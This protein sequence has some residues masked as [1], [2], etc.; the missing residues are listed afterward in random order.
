MSGVDGFASRACA[1]MGLFVLVLIGCSDGNITTGNTPP[2]AT[3]VQ[4][5]SGAQ[6]SSTQPLELL[7]VAGDTG[8]SADELR[9]TWSVEPG[10]VLF[11]G[12][13]DD[14]DGNTRFLWE[15]PPLGLVRISLAVFD[16][17]GLSDTR[18]IEV[19]VVG[20]T[21][22]TC[23]ITSPIDTDPLDAGAEVLLQAQVSD[24]ESPTDQVAYTWSSDLDGPLGSG[25]A[26]SAG[27]IATST[28]LSVGVHL[29]TLEV[30]DPLGGR[31]TTGQTVNMN[32]R[33]SAPVL[34]LD[35]LLP[36]TL[37]DLRVEVTTASVDPEGTQVTYS[38][39]WTEDMATTAITGDVVLA[40][41][42]DKGEV[43]EVSVVATDEDGFS[44]EPVTA[45]VTVANSPP[46]APAVS[47]SPAAPTQAEDL[48]CAVDVPSTDADG[49]GVTYSYAWERDGS[50]TGLA[51]DTLAWNE[52]AIGEFWTCVAT[53]LDGEDAGV[54]GTTTV[55][56]SAG[57][58][59][60]SLS[61]SSPGA[62]DVPTS[63]A[64]D[65]TSGDFTLEAWA[66]LTG[67]GAGETTTIASTRG[68]TSGSGWHFGV[69]GLQ[70]AGVQ[71]LYFLVSDLNG[72]Y[73]ESSVSVPL[74]VWTHLAVTFDSGSGLATLWVDGFNVGSATIAQPTATAS[75]F[76]IGADASTGGLVWN[77][78]LDDVRVSDVVRYSSTFV[79]ASQLVAD[80]DT[81]AWWGFE[82]ASGG[83]AKDLSGG[84]HDGTLSG[85]AAFDTGD[86]TCSNDQ[87]PTAPVV[88]VSPDYPLLSEDLIC[89]LINASVDP[90]G[91]TVTYDGQWL[92][93]GAPTG[94]TFS[95]FPTVLPASATA[96]GEEW[97]CSVTAS[98]GGQ[99]GPAGVDSVFA[100]AMPIGELDVSSPGSPA[101]LSVNF[102]P[103]V[104]G[105]VRAT[106][107]NPDASRDGVFTIDVLGYGT[108]WV[109]T[110]Y[111]DW[112]YGGATVA[113]WSTTDVEFNAEPSLGT[114]T[115]DLGYDPG[116]GIDNT[117]PDTLSLWFV[118]D[119]QLS[120]SGATFVMGS[121][122]GPQDT[123]LSQ[124]QIVTSAAE[125]LLLE[126]VACGF[127]GGGHGLYADAD[128]V[129]G[130]D[131]IARVDTG[132]AGNCLIPLE[133]RPL[134]GGTWNMTLAN[135]DDFFTDN[136]D[137]REVNL[138]RYTP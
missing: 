23:S 14:A 97:T 48:L 32:G 33:P 10:G 130:N 72:D 36:T 101:S 117:G 138:Y 112:A 90:E 2:T 81:A 61:A 108:T 34:S 82:E 104:V 47:V 93:D 16:P 68:V 12:A 60:L 19:E 9:V 6:H 30:E 95:T 71:R 114:L 70:T 76:V 39:A 51:G 52:T 78:N 84:A 53:P 5:A 66:R 54:P 99:S 116:A 13:P 65:L 57:C 79:P 59:S 38:Y 44:A 31:C 56:V 89:S 136:T 137:N 45:T 21:D 73:A 91:A 50:A 113:G 132:F 125:R 126:T 20:N 115:L 86:S 58:S 1:P 111:R 11:D 63:S 102:T 25:N 103:P 127:G 107:D 77:G 120:T 43:W 85:A 3:I 26:D 134:G 22:P 131:G 121:V 40:A 109:F 46:S 27:V 80:A 41:D 8:T 74:N 4:P 94:Q 118:Y 35:P 88:A 55:P 122:V 67:V 105:L 87:P 24:G 62:V 49:D 133:S 37:D 69:G 42:L 100:G 64:I 28:S 96:E 135:E 83:A 123:T 75:D 129:V 119:T 17:G 29:V 92:V 106:L 110:G 98:D 18:T 124:A 15:E 128:G 7:G